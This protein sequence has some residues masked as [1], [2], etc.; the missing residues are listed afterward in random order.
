M[1]W[2]QLVLWSIIPTQVF[3][4][5]L[6]NTRLHPSASFEDSSV[7]QLELR[8][9]FQMYEA[10]G[11]VA[12]MTIRKPIQL[13]WTVFSINGND[14]EMMKYQ[15]ASGGDYNDPYAVSASEFEWTEHTVEYQLFADEAPVTV[16]NFKTYADDGY[17]NNTIVHRNESTGQLFGVDGLETFSPLPIIQSGGFRLYDTDDY[18]LEWVDA[19][20]PIIFEET[21]QSTKGT[22]AMARTAA[23]D[24]ATSQF[25]INLEDNSQAW[26]SAY[27]V[28]GELLD[29]EGDQP[30]LD[31][32]AN[33]DVYDLSTPKPSGQP[34]VFAGL[35]FSSIPLYTPNWNEKTS[36]I[37]FTGV[38]VSNGNP[39]GI[40]YSW[41]WVEGHEASESFSIE[42]AGSSLNISSTSA[43][44]GKIRVYGTSSGQTK[45]FDIDLASTV[46]NLVTFSLTTEVDPL[47]AGVISQSGSGI[48]QEGE[49]VSVTVQANPGYVFSSWGGDFSGSANPLNFSMDSDKYLL[50]NFL[51]DINDDDEDG[52]SNYEES[53]V[54]GTNPNLPDTDSDGLT[55]SDELFTYL[56]DPLK[57]DTDGDGLGDYGEVISLPTNPLLPDTDFDG[58]NDF[59]EVTVYPTD[60]IAGDTD[61]DGL[62]DGQEVLT[63]LTDPMLIDSDMDGF[64]DKFEIETGYDPTTALSVP[65]TSSGILTAV[66]FFFN[67]ELGTTYRIEASTDLD[68]WE[69]IESG[70]EGT[71]AAIHRLYS[72]IGQEKRFL[73]AEPETY[74]EPD[75]SMSLISVG[76]FTMGS[77]D[78]EIG[79]QDDETQHTVT[80]TKAFYL[81]TTEVT[82]AQWDEVAAEGPARDYTDLPAGRNG[83]N[84]DASLTHPVTE[85]S[86]YDVVKWLNLKSELEG[87]T[88]CYTVG[89]VVMKTGTSIPDC[90][91]DANGYRLPTESEWE[92]ACR[93]GTSTAF[94]NGPITYTGES[95]VDPIL[96]EI[97]WYR[98]NSGINTHP[99]GRKQANAWG[100]YD[101]SGNVF[102]WC[103]DWAATYPGTVTDPTGT[104]SGARRAIRGGNFGSNFGTNL[105]SY[106]R[107]CRSAARF[108][109]IPGIV[110]HD[111]GFRPARSASP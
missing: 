92:Y 93:A 52:L 37:R 18:L 62:T 27:S 72:M 59:E 39:E 65:P 67:A 56:T 8:D 55:D 9:F 33:T 86:W 17:Y 75:A 38:S 82:K 19:R 70:I 96:D 104:A 85:V 2:I 20:P 74:P 110:Y 25:F 107:D 97:G 21:R 66:E 31:D 81:Q 14:V 24:S 45:S 49:E 35:P 69:V 36:Y 54:Y 7:L 95:P 105:G 42:L 13:G 102:E 48:Y 50:A 61:G 73:R 99:V 32:F 53:V 106:A 68:N 78:D 5:V 100:L 108:N 34:N 3:G 91:F 89:G 94:Y 44:T 109:R 10:P 88:P 43:G 29:P 26:G 28:F 83:Y 22:I 80:L 15:L 87:L 47:G 90:D 111:Q 58:L 76:T 40:S 63:Y 41:E 23:L 1:R 30:I 60:P 71:G 101:M 84:G 51:Y 46:T 6:V 11:P 98:G 16:A 64:N 4:L 77:P 57:S 79:R 103:W 12:T